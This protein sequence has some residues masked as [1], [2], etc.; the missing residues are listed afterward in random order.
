MVL[1]KLLFAF[2]TCH[3]CCQEMIF[4]SMRCTIPRVFDWNYSLTLE[5]GPS[6]NLT[7]NSFSHVCC[8]VRSLLWSVHGISYNVDGTCKGFWG[9]FLNLEIPALLSR[10][11]SRSWI[12]LSWCIRWLQLS[13]TQQC[14]IDLPEWRIDRIC[15]GQMTFVALKSSFQVLDEW[16][17]V[18][19][20]SLCP[21][22]W[23]DWDF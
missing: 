12:V 23:L 18:E 6:Q 7:A 19:L 10:G 2:A 3:K 13:S 14:D 21:T 11:C 5:W 4:F 16:F 15:C 8:I 9:R 20:P 1:L 17:L 22:H